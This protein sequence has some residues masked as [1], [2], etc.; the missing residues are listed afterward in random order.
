[1]DS[2]QRTRR[3]AYGEDGRLTA[4]DH[5]GVWLSSRQI[6]RFAGDVAGRRVADVGCGY[7]AAFSRT[8][9]PRVAGLTLIDVSLA[10]DLLAH[11][12]VTA[13]E[14]HLP[15]ALAALGDRSQD[16]VVCNSVLEHLWEPERTLQELLRVL[17]PGGALLLNVPSWRGKWFLELSAF[18]LGLS[19]AAEMNDHKTYY[20]PRDL[21][22]LLIRAGFEPRHVR[23]FRH[24]L[25]LNTFAACRRA[26]E[27]GP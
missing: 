10:P 14:G 17:V 9:L 21:W 25:G 11:P 27:P 16:V 4:V 19:P 3:H 8:L 15:D 5:L 1:M 20:D 26:P 22:P 2:S 18:R 12:G 23:C 13:I 7:R 24:K 6:R